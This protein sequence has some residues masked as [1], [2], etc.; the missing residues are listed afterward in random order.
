MDKPI[1]MNKRTPSPW[2]VDPR[3]QELVDKAIADDPKKHKLEQNYAD[4]LLTTDLA[5]ADTLE[6][7]NDD[8]RGIEIQYREILKNIRYYGLENIEFL[9][10]ELDVLE[11][12]LGKDWMKTLK[13]NGE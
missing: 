13:E 12:K 1:P 3:L 4:F 10:Y 9:P 2:Y 8:V 7:S 11:A 6:G 5:N